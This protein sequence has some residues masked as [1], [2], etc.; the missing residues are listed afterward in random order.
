[1]ALSFLVSQHLL[2]TLF[3]THASGVL[4][5]WGFGVLGSLPNLAITNNYD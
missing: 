5:F 4:G 3:T 1:M 2:L